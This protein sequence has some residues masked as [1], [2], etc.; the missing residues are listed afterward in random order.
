[1]PAGGRGRLA[2]A[3]RLN[4]DITITYG[5]VMINTEPTKTPVSSA[6]VL[7][8]TPEKYTECGKLLGFAKRYTKSKPHPQNSLK[9]LHRRLT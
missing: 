1:M 4:C 3:T 6:T 5:I 8:A 2:P 7:E 9:A